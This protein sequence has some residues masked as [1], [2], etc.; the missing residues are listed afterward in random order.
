MDQLEVVDP[1]GK[2]VV[3]TSPFCDR[4]RQATPDAACPA[5]GPDNATVVGDPG[6][7]AT[8]GNSGTSDSAGGYVKD[9]PVT[10]S[11]DLCAA[12]IGQCDRGISNPT[13]D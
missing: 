4:A 6:Q 5:P 8:P 12:H 11:T 7:A 2:L 10:P 3:V 1:D 13:G 9:N